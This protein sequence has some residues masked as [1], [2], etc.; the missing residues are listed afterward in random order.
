[1]TGEGTAGQK[2]HHRCPLRFPGLQT[3]TASGPSIHG[4]Q[5]ALSGELALTSERRRAG[6]HAVTAVLQPGAVRRDALCR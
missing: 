4:V 2:S 5:Q 1:M 3:G 6:L